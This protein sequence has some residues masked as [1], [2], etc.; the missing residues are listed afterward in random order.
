MFSQE[1]VKENIDVKYLKI[2]TQR[3]M[4]ELGWV[5]G[6]RQWPLLMRKR[7]VE[8]SQPGC[9]GEFISSQWHHYHCCITIRGLADLGQSWNVDQIKLAIRDGMKYWK[10]CGFRSQTDLDWNPGFTALL[11]THVT[12]RF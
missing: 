6:T 3:W 1:I 10:N 9:L 11:C 12:L 4:K 2:E 8:A 5:E 7:T